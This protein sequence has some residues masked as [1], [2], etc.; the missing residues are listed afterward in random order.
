MGQVAG[1]AAGLEE[2]AGADEILV[3]AARH[4]SPPKLQST[5]DPLEDLDRLIEVLARRFP[6]TSRDEELS[7]QFEGHG[8]EGCG[9]ARRTPH[10]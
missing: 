2:V 8:V 5:L 10:W 3:L 6:V 7:A 4:Q 1:G 9:I